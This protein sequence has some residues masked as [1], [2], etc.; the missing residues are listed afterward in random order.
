M[1]N[2]MTRD[3][4]TRTL[5]AKIQQLHDDGVSAPDMCK[6]LNLNKDVI[7]YH[8]KQMGLNQPPKPVN[9][10][11]EQRHEI[12]VLANNRM[13]YKKIAEKFGIAPYKVKTVVQSSDSI[14]NRNI[15]DILADPINRLLA[16][17]WA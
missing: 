12:K 5:R 3:E 6:A 15:G 1:R 17:R 7:Y 4:K 11:S 13:S 8:R 2:T 9:L 14:Q 10:T 16:R